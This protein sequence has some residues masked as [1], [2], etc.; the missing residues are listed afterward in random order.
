MPNNRKQLINKFINEGFTHRTLSLFSDIQLKELHKKVFKEAV[1]D[2][3]ERHAKEV[4]IK[5]KEEEL[6]QLDKVKT[7]LLKKN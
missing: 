1:S 3:A 6:K 2:E 7:I 4:L 5:K